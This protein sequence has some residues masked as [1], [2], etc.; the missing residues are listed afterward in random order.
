M[1]VPLLIDEGRVADLLN[2]ADSISLAREVYVRTAKREALSPE[3]VILSVPHGVSVFTMPSH[4][5]GQRTVSVKV[6]R[7]NPENPEKRLHSVMATIYVYDS[8]SGQELARVEADALTA[9][10]TAASSA[11]A[12]DLLAPKACDTLGI[13]GTGTEASA[14][15]PALLHVRKFSH[16][17]VY[18]RDSGRRRSFAHRIT[19]TYGVPAK[20]SDTP[21]EMVQ[22]SQV[23]LLATNSSIPLFDGELVKPGTHVNAIGAALPT[24]RETDTLLVKNS[25][26][27]VDSAAQAKSSYG[28]ILIPLREGAIGQGDISELGTL[29][30][31]P[32]KI[33]RTPKQ[34]TLFKS[35]GLAALDA[36][37]ADHL[38]S[39]AHGPFSLKL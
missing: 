23:L 17:L 1:A 10:R 28:D 8:V 4:V 20:A 33:P 12:T 27:V 32:G 6:A 7:L 21:K 19:K 30:V 37:F 31:N 34:I 36:A 3:R 39:K 25:F 26:L 9:L 38:L 15:V 11:V 22:S 13:F 29:L 16:I 2:I 5:L 24:D 35:G 14:H 18:S